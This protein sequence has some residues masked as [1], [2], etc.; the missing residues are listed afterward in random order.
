MR[1]PLLLLALCGCSES[2]IQ[3]EAL[4]DYTTDV[5]AT[6]S[7]APG[8]PDDGETSLPPE[9]EGDRRMLPPA[10]TDVYVFVANPERDTV[11][12]VNVRTLDVDTTAVGT[13][14]EIVAATSDFR[15][16]VVFNDGDDSVTILDAATLARQTV[17]VRQ[18]LNQMLLSP[19]GAWAVLWHDSALQDPDDPPPEGLQSF[20]EVSFV[21]LEDGVHFPMAVG[22]DPKMV[23]FVPDSSLAVVVSDAYLATVDLTVT[24]LLP[25]LIELAP[26]V[27]DP[28]AAEEV[29]VSD[30]G[31]FAWVRQFGASE[32]LVVNLGDGTVDSV[33]AGD[34]PT[35]LDLSPD[36]QLAVAVARS[37]AELYLFDAH[38]PFAAP[39]I[40][41]LPAEAQY[42][43]LL[44]DPTGSRGVLYTTA[45][46]S[47]RFAVWSVQGGEVVERSLVK[48][49][50]SMA[51]TPTGDSLL[52]FH[53]EEDGPETEPVFQGQSALTLVDLS[54]FRSN[55]LLLPAEPTGYATSAT[56]RLG[57]FIMEDAPFL[58]VLDFV[59]LLPTEL[60]LASLPVFL[61][62]LP[63]LDPSDGDEP[64]AWVSQEHELGRISFFDPDEPDTLETI[65]GFELNSGIE[66]EQ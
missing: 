43:S 57:Y 33:A 10:Q 21:G 14:P 46:L 19:D 40:V 22:F 31:S 50:D 13:R 34:N 65:T 45:Q 12:R 25:D 7:P 24:P 42:G 4:D 3:G 63:D 66:E 2:A 15:T 20:N 26:G 41:P 29:I 47:E 6:G 8:E 30:D 44:F 37:S 36:G 54:D 38:S 52:V 1:S 11:T 51:V 27:L 23:R 28:P 58:E 39:Q 16:A 55:P 53:T 56:G 5:D 32:L 9:E 59:T 18:N 48:P 49:V 17:D 35:D 61:G 60:T 62:V 64:P